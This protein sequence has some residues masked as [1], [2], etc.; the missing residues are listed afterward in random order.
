MGTKKIFLD[1]AACSGM[2]WHAADPQQRMPKFSA[3]A[4]SR[5]QRHAATCCG[6]QRRWSLD[7]VRAVERE[8]GT[9]RKLGRSVDELERENGGRQRMSER[10][11]GGSREREKERERERKR[12]RKRAQEG[13]WAGSRKQE[14]GRVRGTHTSALDMPSSRKAQDCLTCSIK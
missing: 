1:A 8:R 7:R 11:T 12:Q 6:M 2:Q 14:G 4:C 3:A 9:K 13:P 10:G 5:M